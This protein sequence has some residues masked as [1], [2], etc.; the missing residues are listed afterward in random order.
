MVTK[1]C[2]SK[3]MAERDQVP[4]MNQKETGCQSKNFQR[5]GGSYSM[6]IVCD[7]DR[8]KGEGKARGTLT[9]NDHF[10][11]TYDFKGTMQ[12]KPVTQHH[13]SSGRWLA[14]DCGDV[15]PLSELMPKK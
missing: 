2:I 13:E 12:G 9:G 3:E 5:S 6:D 4:Q 8:M 14:A 1:V 7:G 15:R 11:S 10:S